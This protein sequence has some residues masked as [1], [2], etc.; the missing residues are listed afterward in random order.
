MKRHLIGITLAVM[1]VA[2]GCGDSRTVLTV[3][4]PHGKEQL[5]LFE[6]RFEAL[7]PEVD[8]Q[9]VDMGS[10][11]V[12][13]R[14]RSE[15][16]NPQADVWYGGPALFFERAAADELLEPYRPSWAGSV[17]P[18]ARG[19]GDH[20]FGV[21]LTPAVIAYNSEAVDSAEAPRDWDDVLE[22]RWKG[23]VLIRDPLASGTMRTIF[24]MIM[25]R[26][27]QET[28]DTAA[29]YEW[30]RKLDAQTKEYVLNPALLYQK[31]ARQEGVITLWN[32]P[33]VLR[34]QDRVHL[35]YVLPES[36]TPVLVD[37]VAVVRGAEQGEWARAFVDY[38]GSVEGQLLA[39][40]SAYR[41]IT[42][43]DIPDDS[44]P[45]WLVNVKRELVPMEVDWALLETRGREWM[46]YW[47][48]S[49]RGQG[50]R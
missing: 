29:G 16:A 32:L 50:V 40:R 4:S 23:E 30:L 21:Y 43:T 17:L 5:V 13:D 6:E 22:P 2:F 41:N 18:E 34:V 48:A 12:L 9:W 10:Q 8:V 24:G 44:L 20:Y 36:G 25:Y 37:G 7:H 38:L 45:D 31:L 26:S 27:I 1:A 15:S 39:A 46:R 47:D 33:D 35:A 49:I 28:G 3:Y 11:E 14:V 42:R 19:P